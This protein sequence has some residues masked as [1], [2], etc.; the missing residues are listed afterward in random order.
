MCKSKICRVRLCKPGQ[1]AEQCICC[2]R[3]APSVQ[4]DLHLTV[5]AGN[6]LSQCHSPLFLRLLGVFLIFF[7]LFV[8][9]RQGNLLWFMLE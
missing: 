9:N 7:F 3:S 8:A 2:C 6:A 4:C 1:A 5:E